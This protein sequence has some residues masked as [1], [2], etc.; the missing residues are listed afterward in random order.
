MAA[1]PTTTAGQRGPM[2]PLGFGSS[3][4][5]LHQRVGQTWPLIS[6]LLAD[7]TYRARYRIHLANAAVSDAATGCSFSGQVPVEP[8]CQGTQDWTRYEINLPVASHATNINFGM[9]HAGDGTAWFDGLTV[10]LDGV[11]Y[12]NPSR[13]DFD[14]ES[15]TPVGF[16]TGGN[17]YQV[18]LDNRT[19]FSGQQSLKMQFVG[20]EAAAATAAAAW[21]ELIDH[22]EASRESY[23]SGGAD[24]RDIEWIIQ[25]ARVAT[26]S[27]QSRANQVSRDTSM[28]LNVDWILK[29]STE[30]K[31]VLWAHNEHV[32]RRRWAS[33]RDEGVSRHS[34]AAPL[35]RKLGQRRSSVV[36]ATCPS[37]RTICCSRIPELTE[38]ACPGIQLSVYNSSSDPAFNARHR[39]GMRIDEPMPSTASTAM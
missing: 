28:A 29:Q 35:R 31:V 27:M 38:R 37:R 7:D 24:A 26:Q 34:R 32:N 16:S 12:S 19:A 22:F 1:A 14:F 36:I 15:A 39:V 13:F 3:D 10:E 30:A 25:N 2:L 4:D 18:K 8:R 6:R 21:K 5:V 17:G 33:P 20:Y 11:L 23:A 9:L